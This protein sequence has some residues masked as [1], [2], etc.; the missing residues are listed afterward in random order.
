MQRTRPSFVRLATLRS[1]LIATVGGGLLLAACAL[2]VQPVQQPAVPVKVPAVVQPASVPVI[3]I[4]ASEYT[5][6]VPETIEGGLVTLRLKNL[7]HEAHHAQLLRLK[8]GVTLEQFMAALPQG[9]QAV[10]PL[11]TAE[12]GPAAID[13]QGTSE[14]TLNLREGQ[15]VLAC[16]LPSPDGAP[17]LAKGM[18]K[19]L[20]VTAPKSIAAQPAVSGVITLRDF[21]INMPAT[22]PAGRHSYQVISEGPQWHEMVVMRLAP[23]KTLQ[24]AHSFFTSPAGGPPPFTWVGGMQGLEAGGAGIMTLDLAPGEYAAVCL[25]PDAASGKPHF[26]LG[27]V[28]NFTVR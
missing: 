3:T 20:R 25:I 24:D 27:M 13:H 9:E 18:L 12:G 23:G 17:H 8:D 14:V 22:L 16:F 28:A 4:D 26:H 2:P 21:S 19:P 15:Y 5:F 1:A 7:G 6:A 10:F 11:L